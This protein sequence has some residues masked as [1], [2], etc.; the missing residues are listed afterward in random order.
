MLRC[1]IVVVAIFAFAI[2]I[3][4]KADSPDSAESPTRHRSHKQA[5]DSEI[6]G[7]YRGY[8]LAGGTKYNIGVRIIALGEN[9]FR[10]VAYVGGLPGEGEEVNSRRQIVSEGE[11]AEDGS[12]TFES[13]RSTTTW[14]DGKLFVS[15]G[16]RDFS[17]KRI[18]RRSPTLGKKPP[19]NATVLFDGTS[20]DEW[21][22]AKLDGKLLQ[23]GAKS[24][25]EFGNFKLHLEFQVPLE[26]DKRG[27]D[28]GNSGVVIHGHEIQIL[29]SFGVKSEHNQCG[30]IVSVKKPDASMCYP[31]LAWQTFDVEFT[32]GRYSTLGELV[33]PPLLNV[34]HNGVLVHKDVELPVDEAD[35]DADIRLEQAGSPVRFRNIWVLQ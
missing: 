26:T 34:R 12:V 2:P 20:S 6:Q 29:D 7:E 8:I 11:R 25:R 19:R 31:P 35:P 4:A 10:S 32:Q 1:K 5:S 23:P 15:L 16:G 13:E 14:R 30:G 28:R 9:K 27:Q 22:D 17:Y 18:E 24:R 33:D 3:L 21:N